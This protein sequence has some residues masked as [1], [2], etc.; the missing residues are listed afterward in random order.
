[1]RTAKQ[2]LREHGHPGMRIEGH[3]IGSMPDTKSRAQGAN[4]LRGDIEEAGP[5]TSWRVRDFAEVLFETDA[6]H[7]EILGIHR[8][9]EAEAEDDDD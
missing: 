9:A 2:W 5:N 3:L 8:D 1:M 7:K 4:A 6:A